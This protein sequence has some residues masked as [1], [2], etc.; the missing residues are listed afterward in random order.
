MSETARLLGQRSSGQVHLRLEKSGI[1][2]MREAGSAKCR[3]PR[4]SSEVIL[5]NTSGGLAGGDVV[6][7]RAEAGAD[8]E[9]TLNTQ[10]A[11]RIYRTLGPAASVSVT[12][13]AA[14]GSTL[15]WLPQETI[16]FEGASLAR[17]FDVEL[18]ADANFLAV[19][20]MVFGRKEMGEEVR[21]VTVRDRW[22]VRQAGRLIHAEE[23]RLGPK[24]AA[25]DATFGSNRA[26][27][28]LLLV[29]PLAER[30]LE[31]LR[32]VLG[33]EDGA[34]AWNGKLLARFLA[35]DGFQ[36]RKTL[37]QALCVCVGR[38]CLPKCWTF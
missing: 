4:G 14:P 6:D 37:I 23:F 21:T 7:V 5:I 26:C 10:A 11:E 29:S 8:A 33:P 12:L 19:E 3:L 22:R 13:R 38:A 9:L 25:S 34:S 28:T 18:A 31:K 27:A 30:L 16:L 1:A 35:R 32:E 20:A 36:L 17:E 15:R 24:W 2:V